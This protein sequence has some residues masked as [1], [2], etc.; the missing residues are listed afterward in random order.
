MVTIDL[1]KFG[2]RKPW[3]AKIVGESKTYGFAREFVMPRIVGNRYLFDL[4]DGFYEV[5]SREKTRKFIEVLN[6][7]SRQV[8]AKEVKLWVA[9]RM[10]DR[11]ARIAADDFDLANNRSL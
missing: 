10:A 1:L 2:V 4:T 11:I 9:E 5:Q 8:T 7:A 3:I 6:D